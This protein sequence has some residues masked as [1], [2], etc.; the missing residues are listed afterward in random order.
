MIIII[1]III[2]TTFIIMMIMIIIIIN[3]SIIIIIMIIIIIIVSIEYVLGKRDID[4]IHDAQL[5]Y[6]QSCNELDSDII[7]TSGKGFNNNV[8]YNWFLS[9][10]II[11]RHAFGIVLFYNVSYKCICHVNMRF[12]ALSVFLLPK[13]DTDERL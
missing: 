5:F 11:E 10:L 6:R 12:L 8:T 4:E 13:I 2:I 7:N 3:I 1:T 9:R